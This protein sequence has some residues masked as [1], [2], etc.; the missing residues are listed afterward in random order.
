MISY[1]LLFGM[2][3]F[4]IAT[5]ALL[6]LIDLTSSVRTTI[7]SGLHQ[8][9]SSLIKSAL[10]RYLSWAA[11]D[12]GY[13]HLRYVPNIITAE[14]DPRLGETEIT[15]L[16]EQRM[17]ALAF[18]QREYLRVDRD[19]EDFMPSEGQEHCP[20][21]LVDRFLGQA[22][23]HHAGYAP[24]WGDDDDDGE[25]AAAVVYRREPPIVYGLFVLRSSVFLLTVD[26]A[27]GLDAYVSF[28]VDMHFMDRHQSVWNAL[29]IAIAVCLARDQLAA[30]VEDFEESQRGEGSESD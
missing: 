29:T 16:M 18:L 10:D 3:P 12:G 24:S 19:D 26:S 9:A 1:P 30:R 13:A 23:A 15:N 21:A 5:M 6:R 11:Q 25:A 27:K 8:K 28:H 7:Q 20:A 22:T 14:L 17:R 4:Q 2:F